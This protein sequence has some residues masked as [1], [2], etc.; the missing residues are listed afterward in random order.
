MSNELALSEKKDLSIFSPENFDH[1]H[2]IASKMANSE[3]V[4]K[5]YRTKPMDMLICME[6]G[7]SI[8]L[9]MMQ[10]LQNI[11]VINGKPAVYGD[12]LLA[13]V[14][15]HSSYEWIREEP[16]FADNAASIVGYKCTVK[17]RNHEEHTYCFTM[18]DAKKASLWGKPGPWSQYPSRMLQ[19]RARGFALRNTFADA[20]QGIQIVEEIQDS[21]TIDAKPM[22]R[23]SQ[24]DKM[25]ALLSKKR[26]ITHEMESNNAA[27]GDYSD[28]NTINTASPVS[29]HNSVSEK[30]TD[31]AECLDPLAGHREQEN[32]SEGNADASLLATEEQL[33][34][35]DF[36]LH[37]KKFDPSRISKAF[38][39]YN[40][41]SFAELNQEQAN[42]M[43][44]ILEQSE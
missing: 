14:Q 10:S 33:E 2:S 31:E 12:S 6:M 37:E 18:E 7:R 43:I 41:K 38:K 16:L 21:F 9:S 26:T 29:N 34:T 15:G 17:R 22:P 35:I 23:T 19:M 20:L 28:T 11:A 3:L 8:G 32:A 1:W 27:D 30:H 42:E 13:V 36:L 24:D 39:H 25:N 4:P 40:V 44:K 5:N